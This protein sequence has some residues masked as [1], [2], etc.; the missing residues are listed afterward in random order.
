MRAKNIYRAA[1]KLS[2]KK[3]RVIGTKAAGK[4]TERDREIEK[5]RERDGVGE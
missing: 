1:T 5:V 2:F 3:R 4:E